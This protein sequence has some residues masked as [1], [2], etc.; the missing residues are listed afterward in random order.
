MFEQYFNQYNVKRLMNKFMLN[1]ILLLGISTASMAG[2]VEQYVKMVGMANS[3]FQKNSRS[4]FNA[5]DPQQQAFS[6]QQQ[7]QYCQL[8]QDYV[9]DLYTAVEQNL[10]I[11]RSQ[12]AYTKADVINEVLSKREMQTLAQ[13]GVKC[14]LK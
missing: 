11:F 13:Y 7:Q 12:K 1:S 4:F 5:L 10:D 3:Q 6:I 14:Q 8:V 9:D 2:S